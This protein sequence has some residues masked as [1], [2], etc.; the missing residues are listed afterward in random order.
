M[1]DGDLVQLGQALTRARVVCVGDVMLDRFV[2]GQ[3]ERVSPEAPIPVLAVEREE[4]SLGGAGNVL[5]NLRGARRRACF[6]YGRRHRRG[7]ARNRPDFSP[8]RPTPRRI[9]LTERNRVTTVKTRYIGGQQQL[10]RADRE[11]AAPLSA[12]V[13]ADLLSAVPPIA[14]GASG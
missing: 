1:S 6:V 5:R 4:A 12:A 7:R 10:L 13:R 8:A 9:C 2:Y 3:V 11:Q 14:E